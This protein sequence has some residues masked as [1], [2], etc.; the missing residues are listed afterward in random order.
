MDGV[1]LSVEQEEFVAV[2]GTSGSGKSTMLNMLGGLD[3][4]TSGNVIDRGKELSKL[5]D[6]FL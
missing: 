2:A 1:N 5:P 4:P 3:V 6:I